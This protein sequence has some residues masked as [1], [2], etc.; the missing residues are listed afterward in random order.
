M[1]DPGL[2]HRVRDYYDGKLRD[3]GATPRGVDWNSAESQQRRFGELSRLWRDDQTATI[4][5][6]G[7]GYGAL[8]LWLRGRG[9]SGAYT[10]FDVSETMIAAAR[11]E[12]RALTGCTFTIDR[13]H[14]APA[15]Y[16]AASGIFNVKMDTPADEWRDYILRTIDDLASLA[17]RGFAF[18]ALTA[19]S[20]ADRQ[21]ADLYYADP[22]SLFDHCRRRF[23]RHVALLHDYPLYEFTLIVRLQAAA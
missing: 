20:D 12:T 9:H 14:L 17:G 2:L 1:S 7:C 6:Y 15:D 19:Y 21:R 4:V 18:N 11:H 16:V 22:L 10:G 23:S 8:A 13:H 5:D 3:H